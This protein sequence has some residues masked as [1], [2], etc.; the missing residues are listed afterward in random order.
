MME[1]TAPYWESEQWIIWNSA[2]GVRDFVII[3]RVEAG[4]QSRVAWLEEPYGMVGPFDF[5]LLE[6]EGRISFAACVV[7]SRKRWNEDRA[8]LMGEAMEKRRKAQE[9]LFE[10][11]ARANRRK[12]QGGSPFQQQSEREMRELLELPAEGV[13]EV[14]Q[15]KAAYRQLAKKAHPDVG[16]SHEHFVRIT[17]ARDYLLEIIVY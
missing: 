14:S 9:Q 6:S 1:E 13:L 15:V 17:V 8:A 3:D 5:D 2:L 11:L 7:M 4:E 16:G 12:R 10:D